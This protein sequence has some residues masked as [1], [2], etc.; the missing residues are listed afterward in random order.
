VARTSV[1]DLEPF[2]AAD[3]GTLA[4]TAPTNATIT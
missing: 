3:A 1:T 4:T 2:G